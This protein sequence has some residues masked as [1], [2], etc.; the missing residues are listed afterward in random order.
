MLLSAVH[1]G[2]KSESLGPIKASS[3]TACENHENLTC[4]RNL[5]SERKLS[6]L[7]LD[8]YQ[9]FPRVANSFGSL[10]NGSKVWMCRAVGI[11][12]H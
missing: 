2:R 7:D 11:V 4:K 9:S 8:N 6:H 5:S 3:A 1:S 12:I 10:N